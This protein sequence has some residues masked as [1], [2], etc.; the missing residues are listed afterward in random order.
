MIRHYLYTSLHF[1]IRLIIMASI[2]T[3]VVHY[4]IILDLYTSIKATMILH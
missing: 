1:N 3:I 2:T 4:T